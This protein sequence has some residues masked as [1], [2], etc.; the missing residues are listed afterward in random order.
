MGV[1]CKHKI[2]CLAV[3]LL[4]DYICPGPPGYLWYMMVEEAGTARGG[5]EFGDR[6][7]PTEDAL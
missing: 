4:S 5:C 7:L 2:G 6:T 1:H 3:S